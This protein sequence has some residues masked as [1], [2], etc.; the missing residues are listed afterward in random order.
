MEFFDIGAVTEPDD[1]S[2]AVKS[3]FK[4]IRA[5]RS[6]WSCGQ[7]LEEAGKFLVRAAELQQ[8]GAQAWGP[9]H[10]DLDEKAADDVRGLLKAALMAYF[11]VIDGG[12]EGRSAPAIEKAFST[13]ELKAANN[14]ILAERHGSIAHYG[15]RDGSA[16]HWSVE[17][18]TLTIDRE[19]GRAA[20]VYPWIRTNAKVSTIRDLALLMQALDPI[21]REWSRKTHKQ[22]EAAIA[23]L[24][25]R[26]DLCCVLQVPF[27]PEKFWAH[28]PAAAQNHW[29]GASEGLRT[30][31]FSLDMKS[32][33]EPP[34]D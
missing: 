20:I 5:A 7:D 9:E 18:I 2:D 34:S 11:R 4:K 33:P 3:L 1:A 12:S 28:N 31:G 6:A 8:A 14:R 25:R 22:V 30:F 17:K 10:W 21:V 27:E 29:D 16:H 23:A 32:V 15:M 24:G 26:G 19:S 13:H